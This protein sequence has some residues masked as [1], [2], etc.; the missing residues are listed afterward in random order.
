M[1]DFLKVVESLKLKVKKVVK[2]QQHLIDENK[3]LKLEISK[4]NKEILR[5][6]SV[7]KELLEECE[8]LKLA[9]SMLGSDEHKRETKLKINF[10]IREIDSCINQLSN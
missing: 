7:S 3:F 10:L 9:N 1:S 5:L 2:I 6:E 4:K 8:S